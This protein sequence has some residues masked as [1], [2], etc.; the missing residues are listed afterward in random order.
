MAWQVGDDQAPSAQVRLQLGEVPG[1]APEAVHEQE[2]RPFAADE[3]PDPGAPMG[4]DPLFEARQEIR[5]IRHANRLWFDHCELDGDKAGGM[6]VP[7]LRPN[8]L[9]IQ[10]R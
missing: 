6:K 10:A 5:R 8:K 9:E 2:R 1:G 3:G 4:K 7:A